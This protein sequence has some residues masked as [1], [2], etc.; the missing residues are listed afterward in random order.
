LVLLTKFISGLSEKHYNIFLYAL[1]I[2]LG[3][4]VGIFSAKLPLFAMLLALLI[5]CFFIFIYIFFKKGMLS[6]Q[7]IVIPLLVASI[8][9]PPIRLPGGIPSIRVQLIIIL[10]AWA[11][12]LLGHFAIGHP[13]KFHQDPVYKYF[14]LF[15]LAILLS[16]TYGAIVKG[17]PVILSGVIFG[18]LE[19]CLN[20]F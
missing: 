14:V 2:L 20:T 12:L 3:L 18:N 11:L 15:G 4:L 8:L 5:T 10:V 13:I 19:N 7:R 16:I 1:I 9:F 17:Y 6:F